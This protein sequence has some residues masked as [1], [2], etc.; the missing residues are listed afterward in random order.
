MLDPAVLGYQAVT[1]YLVIAGGLGLLF[2]L[3]LFL[4]V[5][6]VKTQIDEAEGE[7]VQLT[8]EG[9]K[10]NV[11]EINGKLLVIYDSVRAGAESFL[12]AEFRLCFVFIILFAVVIVVL[13]SHIGTP[14]A[15]FP[16][17]GANSQ[18][19]NWTIG[20]YAVLAYGVGALCSIFTGYISMK[21]AVFS[22]VRTCVAAS[23]LGP[24][25]WKGAFSTAMNAGG[26]DGFL[27]CSC[28]LLVLFFLCSVFELHF[29]S[30]TTHEAKLLFE[31]IAGFG[32]GASSI[33]M[34]GRV[35]GGI[36]TK[37]ADVGSDLAGKVVAGIPED[38]PRNP[39]VIADNV[40][41]NVGDVAGMGSD[42]FGSFA[43]ASC[44]ALIV[45]AT[46]A[47]LVKAGWGALMFPLV[48]SATGIYTGIITHFFATDIWPVKGNRDVLRALKMQ[49]FLS[50]IFI[51]A[52]M[53][54]VIMGFL[55]D[56]FD[57]EQRQGS[58]VKVFFSIC[59]GLW[60]G[61]LIGFVTEY[62]T[63]YT[64]RPTQEV[65]EASRTGAA[66]VVIYGVALGYRSAVIPI[67]ILCVDIFVSFHLLG[68]YG[69]ALCALGM[70]ASLSTCLTIDVY[71][72]ICDNGGGFAEMA[73]MHKAREITDELDAAGNTTA[74]IGKGFAIGSAA[75]VSLSLLGAFVTRV[76]NE[77]E[78][79]MCHKTVDILQ[80]ITFACLVFGAMIPY[81][82]S[83]MTLKSVG[84]AAMAMVEEIKRQFK[85][86][87]GLLAGV[88]GVKP[89][90]EKCIK[91][92]TESS[93]KEMVL[94]GLLIIFTPII[95]GVLLGV[96]ALAGFLCGSMS[97]GVQIAISMSNTGGAWDNAKK[98]V[99]KG[100]LFFDH[101]EEGKLVVDEKPQAKYS[102]A[103][104]ATVV[105]D[106]VGDPF[107]DTSGPAINI[108][109][110]LMAIISLVFADFFMSI[111]DGHGGFNIVNACEK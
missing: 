109:M 63:A 44:A 28:A 107:K 53:W 65:A 10:V 106:T 98:Y 19:F 8:E 2:A 93:L 103:H 85:E 100:A 17:N 55:P 57:I 34:F 77:N 110:K 41:D 74:A 32:L 43:E 5:R 73:G 67:F 35:G 69:V 37:A 75:L 13:L 70:L 36:F 30:S 9:H 56:T 6:S 16:D 20:G 91:I 15:G 48:I 62:F 105:G 108:V 4:R 14:R 12:F 104:K 82:F 38:D 87:D 42:L 81:W 88:Q 11:E 24:A 61:C 59:V 27:L 7:G 25:G 89:E 39:G 72:P 101:E 50:T 76:R 94:P 79:I 60:G 23:K 45:G 71:G 64:Q 95:V 49:L 40:G 90:T 46:S 96:N 92:A 78:L 47:D 58:T 31:A 68:M 99:E 21:V 83:A 80:P 22:N 51:T 66:T 33:A 18:G 3:F 84:K 26:A 97:S 29:G 1:I 111:N 102:E 52:A 54:P 86:I